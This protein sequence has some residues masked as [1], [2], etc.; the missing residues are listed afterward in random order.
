MDNRSFSGRPKNITLQERALAEAQRKLERIDKMRAE[1]AKQV[2]LEQNR[3]EDMRQIAEDFTS[4]IPASTEPN[5]TQAAPSGFESQFDRFK[6]T[7]ANERLKTI[8]NEGIG[9]QTFDVTADK[10]KTTAPTANE[11]FYRTNDRDEHWQ[12]LTTDPGK[13]IYVSGYYFSSGVGSGEYEYIL[14]STQLPIRVGDMIRAPVHNKGHG[15]GKFLSGHDRRFIVTDI[16]SKEKFTPYH[17]VV[18]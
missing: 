11:S 4:G 2:E 18:W 14:G 17:D 8:G 12:S 5:L 15:D 1:M 7:N 9:T 6:T 3:L 16:Y 13:T 10:L